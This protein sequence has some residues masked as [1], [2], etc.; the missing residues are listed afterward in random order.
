MTLTAGIDDADRRLD[1]ILRKAL[2]DL[3]LSA[4]HRFLRQGRVL[5]N[6][7]PAAGSDHIPAGALIEIPETG[8]KS[9][10]KTV[11][12]KAS[13]IKQSSIK[14]APPRQRQGEL[15]I[16]WEGSGLLI[17][18]KPAGLAVHGAPDSLDLRVQSYLAGKLP[19]SLSF[20]PGPLHR[21]DKPT[22]GIIV[23]SKTLEAA[24]RFSAL[25]AQG[26][27]VKRYLA[28]LEGEIK[29]E[30]VW[31]EI[32]V[33]DK[34]ARK[35]LVK[36]A[37]QSTEPDAVPD[38]AQ[39]AAGRRALTLVTPLAWAKRETPGGA[40]TYA[41]MEIKTGRTHQI[42]AQ[43]ASHGHPLAGDRKY[44]GHTFNGKSFFLHAAE[45]ELPDGMKVIAPLPWDFKS[46]TQRHKAAKKDT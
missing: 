34:T 10:I 3:P 11:S 12:V 26:K 39:D 14:T 8:R 6:G 33:R 16:L 29:N 36:P 31:E 25:L 46:L 17:L 30:R 35:T 19:A 13:P 4:L 21:L 27:I 42:R 22:S 5:V 28:I 40:Y 43:A 44:G 20:K 23:F 15:S 7:S 1:R 45:L 38:A 24:R 9:S 37:A 18:N 41:Q 32:L 2:P